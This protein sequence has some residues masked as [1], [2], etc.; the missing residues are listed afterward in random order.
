MKKS[1]NGVDD[2]NS[3]KNNGDLRKGIYLYSSEKIN[4]KNRKENKT[5]FDCE[6]LGNTESREIEN[7]KPINFLKYNLDNNEEKCKDMKDQSHLFRSKKR[8]KKKI[9]NVIYPENN[10]SLLSEII[11]NKNSFDNF[12]KYDFTKKARNKEKQPRYT[13]QDNIRRV[14]KRRFL[15]TYLKNKLNMKL[16]KAGYNKFIDSFSPSFVGNVTRSKN[17]SIIN[18]KFSEILKNKDFSIYYRNNSEIV[19]LVQKDKKPDLNEL[20]NKKFCELYKEYIKSDEFN[21]GEITRLR[22][23]KNKKSEYYIQKYE[24]LA[25]HLIEYFSL[26]D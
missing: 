14:I 18:M 17:N 15:N 5:N 24:Y 21:I 12:R 7:Y 9:F 1:E 13:Y 4:L 3:S 22:N 25:K 8:N 23:S 2:I 19:N 6:N 11:A 20:L 10:S 16:K 26:E